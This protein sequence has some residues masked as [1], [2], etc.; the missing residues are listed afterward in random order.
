[1]SASNDIVFT[2]DLTPLFNPR[3]V[4]VIGASDDPAKWGNM[5]AKHLITAGHSRNV[6]L[7]NRRGGK[8]LGHD[9]LEKISDAPEP[10]DLVCITVPARGLLEAID[11]SLAAGAKALVVITAGLSELSEE[12][13]AIEEEALRRVRAAGA[14]LV[15][16]NCLGVIDSTSALYLSSDPFGAGNIAVLSQSGNMVIDVDRMLAD[17]GL[18]ISRFVSLGNQSDVSLAD[19][20]HAMVEHDGTRAV[21]IYAEDVRNGRAFVTAARELAEVGKPVVLLAPGRS[22]A[23]SRGAASHTG[24]LTS[25]A[26]VIDAACAA[27]GVYR[28][29]TPDQMVHA[30]VSL[31]GPRRAQGRRT[32]VF[33]D[34][35]GHGAIACDALTSRG[36]DV[37]RLSDE[38]GELLKQDMWD[39]SPVFNPVDLAGMGEQDPMSYH[40]GVARLLA[41][42]EVDSVLWIGY[43]GGYSHHRGALFDGECE[44]ARAVVETVNTQSK[45]LVVETMFPDAPSIKILRDG[46]I[47]IYRGIGDAAGAIA[48]LT[49]VI[50]PAFNDSVVLPDAKAP[51][52]DTD[53]IATRSLF[54]EAGVPFPDLA[55]VASEDELL[56]AV[57]VGKP[58]FPVVLKAMGLLHK[59]DAGGVILNLKDEG[60]LLAAYRDL[61]QRLNPPAVTVEAMA[62]LSQGVEVIVG[63]QQDPRFGPVVLVGLGGV[64]TEVLAD[65]AF[66]LAPLSA[67]TA[68]SLLLSLRGAPLLQGARGRAPVD[69]DAL[70]NVVVAVSNVA[71]SHPE[72]A[73][74]EVN[75]VLASASGCIA[76]DARAILAGSDADH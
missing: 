57:K 75:P 13:R 52:T 55:V 2:R 1:V 37:P 40:R 17:E 35:G 60:E 43:F 47:P 51:V 7:V 65:V 12:G 54:A 3:S 30:L 8:V 21:A 56:A 27:G 15:G 58:S 71:A 6:Y 48:A 62:D 70:A 26:R 63:S 24:S 66:A 20:M 45:P 11:D 34:G 41:S 44:A 76:L 73:E 50:S 38:L 25:P 4:G 72:I 53:Y 68:K 5:I 64:F 39:Q 22:P 18:G 59:S 29:E 31:V 46:G 28:V 42:D 49:P 9:V 67:E 19:L 36:M 32:A 69:L 33:T 74:L 61:I 10:V 16:P 23:A 14:H